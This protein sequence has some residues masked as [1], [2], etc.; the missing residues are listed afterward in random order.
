MKKV[1]TLKVENK[2]IERQADTIKAEVKKYL[3][4]ERNKKLPDDCDR[5]EFDC[6]IGESSEKNHNIKAE[7]ISKGI[8]NFVKVEADSFYLEIIARATVHPNKK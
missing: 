6:K 3:K 5:W 7:N 8:D 2:K 4:R 1:F